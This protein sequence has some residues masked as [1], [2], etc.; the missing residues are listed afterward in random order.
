MATTTRTP[1]QTYHQPILLGGAGD[2]KVYRI[3]HDEVAKVSDNPGRLGK[4][5][6]MAKMLYQAGISVP[7]PRGWDDVQLAQERFQKAFIMEHIE[8]KLGSDTM[9]R[10]SFRALDLVEA[11]TNRA[12]R[13]GFIPKQEKFWRNWILRPNGEVV[14]IDFG[15]W[16][17]PEVPNYV[18]PE[19]VFA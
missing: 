19:E 5:M 16:S 4:E 17:H 8:G 9:G 13:F 10:E 14:L 6:K 1:Y 12:R 7:E 11:E 2:G 15:R 3:S 18:N